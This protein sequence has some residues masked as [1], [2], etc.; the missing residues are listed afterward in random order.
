MAILHFFST[1]RVHN[2]RSTGTFIPPSSIDLCNVDDRADIGK[3]T[4]QDYHLVVK[5]G[6]F[7][8]LST[9]R[10]H[11]GR[12]TGR[13]IVY[14]RTSGHSCNYDTTQYFRYL[15]ASYLFA[16]GMDESAGVSYAASN[17]KYTVM[18]T[19][20]PPDLSPALESKL[21]SV[22]C[23]NATWHTNYHKQDA[24]AHHVRYFKLYTYV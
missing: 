9:F 16:T 13:Y 1:I 17:D 19:L 8:C 4:P 12:S 6:N 7:T 23:D 10:V 11:I 21:F 14:I 3:S 5:N 2:G 15:C 18:E 20:T 22:S 24:S